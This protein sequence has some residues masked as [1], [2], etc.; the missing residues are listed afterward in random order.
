MSVERE[1]NCRSWRVGR[2]TVTLS[3]SALTP[4]LG[5][6]GVVEWS[7]ALPGRPLTPTE[8]DE[9]RRGREAAFADLARA[10]GLL[11]LTLEFGRGVGA[12]P[13]STPGDKQ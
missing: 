5:A 9:Y 2:W 8:L 1:V 11:G 6:A 10:R 13:T 4:G 12:S 7:P 3:I